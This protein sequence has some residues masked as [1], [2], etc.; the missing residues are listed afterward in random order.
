[1]TQPEPDHTE[2]SDF[3]FIGAVHGLLKS[4]RSS[5]KADL[6]L[7]AVLQ[8]LY[9][10]DRA[11]AEVVER[12]RQI[13]PGAVQSD[14]DISDAL[15]IGSRL[16]LVAKAESL[17]ETAV[18]TLTKT[19]AD[20]VRQHSNWV[21]EMRSRARNDIQERARAGMLQDLSGGQADLILDRLVHGLAAVVRSSQAPYIGQVD[22]LL[23]T[24]RANQRL[25]PRNLDRDALLSSMGD[26]TG[27]AAEFLR[28]LA[29]AAIDPLDPFGN[30]L[31]SHITTGCILYA[32]V[33]GVDRQHLLKRVGN[34]GDQR[35]VLDTPVLIEL[36][37]P[38]RMSSGLLRTIRS[39]VEAGWE[40]IALEHS[41]E[42]AQQV[43]HRDVPTIQGQLRNAVAT[44][45]REAWYASLT[46]DQLPSLCVEVL[47]EGTYKSLE[48]LLVAA[49]ALPGWLQSLGVLVRPHNNEDNA[50]VQRCFDA[51]TD[52]L[53]ETD[54][55]ARSELVV[56]RDANSMTVVWR[57]RRRP[58]SGSWPGGW[59]IT[60]DRSMGPAY[61]RVN[62]RD[63]VNLAL[64][65]QQWATLLSVSASPVDVEALARAAADQFLDEAAWTLPVR[66]P[67]DVAMDLARQLSPEHGGSETDLRVAQMTLDEALVYP[68]STTIA[69]SVLSGR[70]NRVNNLSEATLQRWSEGMAQERERAQAAE[71]QALKA[72]NKRLDS[73]QEV[74]SLSGSVQRLQSHVEWKDIQLKRVVASGALVIASVIALLVGL[75]AA[76]LQTGAFFAAGL[77]VVA[78]SL[79]TWCRDRNAK[80]W[81][82]LV[83]AVIDIIGVVS[84]LI[85]I[86]DS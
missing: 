73:E 16:R 71:V 18:W 57:R 2:S 84:G 81:P 79:G 9:E 4:T 33:A 10:S 61:V 14:T 64:T 82:V 65:P 20:D 29:L 72:D 42:E 21:S 40:V 38:K 76:G 1:M 39:A 62:S 80:L 19:G 15:A 28:A 48:G 32:F 7:A 3:A 8:A 49:D 86:F 83:G 11:F 17:D 51:L 43:L 31:V 25:S 59:V 74:E 75:F 27:A 66:Y 35:A 67:P 68:D 58:T 24:G 6:L 34:P 55:G 5:Q 23:H 52:V 53:A 37:G 78:Y 12:V 36:L 54:K 30:E 22:A 13:W 47:R 46:E 70:A 44:G 69:A 60:K 41:V 45:S 85:Q 77:V 63:K 50:Q 26:E 56:Q